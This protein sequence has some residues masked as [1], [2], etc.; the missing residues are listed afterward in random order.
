ME[1][2]MQVGSVTEALFMGNQSGK[3][4]AQVNEFAIF[5][6]TLSLS[7]E[8]EGGHTLGRDTGGLS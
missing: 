4:L 1:K 3:D 8:E 5:K 7:M 6:S 2:M